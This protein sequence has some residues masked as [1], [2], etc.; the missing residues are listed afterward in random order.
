MAGG[1]RQ[2]ADSF[3]KDI[4]SAKEQAAKAESHLADALQRAVAAETEANKLKN[5]FADRA[6]TDEQAKSIGN[7]IGPYAGQE[8]DVTPYWD[9]REPLAIANRI[10]DAMIFGGWKYVPPAQT[11][12]LLG[13][14][15]GVEVYVH[16]AAPD[17]VQKAASALVSALNGQGIEAK[18]VQQNPKNPMTSKST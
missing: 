8:F 15:V 14:V 18:V 1:A 16:P 13:G 9:L 4:I 12:I 10:A 11:G 3:E 6:L 7:A 2:E 5:R 17:K